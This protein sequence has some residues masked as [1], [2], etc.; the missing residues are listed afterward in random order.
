MQERIPTQEMDSI[1]NN[2]LS[3]KEALDLMSY[4][5]GIQSEYEANLVLQISFDS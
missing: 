5:V 3:K 1:I 2:T 4:G